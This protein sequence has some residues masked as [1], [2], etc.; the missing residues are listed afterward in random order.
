MYRHSITKCKNNTYIDINIKNPNL[1]LQCVNLQ[2]SHCRI[3]NINAETINCAAWLRLEWAKHL[4]TQDKIYIINYRCKFA[5]EEI[6]T[7]ERI[8]QTVSR[9]STLAKC[10]KDSSSGRSAHAGWSQTRVKFVLSPFFL[11]PIL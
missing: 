5:V 7:H 10:N 3:Y 11:S 4:I 6:K 1:I 9:I 2:W 8:I